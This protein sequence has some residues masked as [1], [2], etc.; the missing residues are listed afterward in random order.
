[1]FYHLFMYLINSI[2][3]DCKGSY[4]FWQSMISAK[5][6]DLSILS[7]QS[8]EMFGTTNYCS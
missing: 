5:N 8:E 7:H 2:H 6:Q 4:Y 3:G 1:M